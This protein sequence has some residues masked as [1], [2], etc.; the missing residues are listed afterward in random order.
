MRLA[1]LMTTEVETVEE[2]EGAAEAFERMRR[3]RIHH[4]VVTRGREIRGVLSARDSVAASGEFE[5]VGDVMTADVVTASPSTTVREAANLL[6]GNGV[7]CL[8]VV[9]RAG[10]L[11][12]IVTTADLL[13]LLGGGGGRP[14]ARSGRR[15]PARRGPRAGSNAR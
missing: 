6:R 8:P 4:L 1:E 11:A 12:G 3:L 5:C 13:Q 15:A 9:D 10:A 14:V 2:G 7:G